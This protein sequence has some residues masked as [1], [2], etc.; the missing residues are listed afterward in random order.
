VTNNGEGEKANE[1]SAKWILSLNTSEATPN[2]CYNIKKQSRLTQ[3]KFCSSNNQGKF[4][5]TTA[6]RAL[7]IKIDKKE[8][9]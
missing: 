5:E 8:H 9:R 7:K 4:K 3:N 6:K 1:A 2:I